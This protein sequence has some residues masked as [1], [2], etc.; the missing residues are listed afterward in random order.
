MKRIIN[1]NEVIPVIAELVK[2]AC[3]E[4]DDN[5]M[6]AFRDA[7]KKEESAYSRDTLELLIK[8]AEFAKKEQVACCHDTGTCVVIMEIGQ[9]VAW[10]GESLV[11]QI[12]EG[13]RRGYREGYLRNSIVKD[14]LDRINTN[15]NTPAVIHTEIVPGDEVTITVMPK[16]G[17]SENMGSFTN[18][19]PANGVEGVKKFILDSVR[20]AGGKTC[21]PI[22]VGVGVGG[23]MDKCAW[24]AKKALL[25]PIGQPNPNPN[26]AALEKELLEEINNMGI[27]TL[28]MG[29]TVTA[30]DVHIEYFPCHI[31]SLPVAVNLQCH[32]SRHATAQ[33]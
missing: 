10:E 11:D 6:E 24:M 1:T 7:L 33:I 23:T 20:F 9:E 17:G 32:A 26:Y 19:V 16:G 25:R 27:G 21:P 2:K 30:L 3:F 22:I 5:L 14:P 29:G 31:T 15:D 12:N 18:L 4:L 13:V 28:G 8:N